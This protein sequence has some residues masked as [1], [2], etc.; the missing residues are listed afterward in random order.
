VA[1]QKL[2][3][4]E[5]KMSKIINEGTVHP[6]YISGAFKNQVEREYVTQP[7]GV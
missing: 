2:L 4:L 6:N 7:V 1:A 5:T 3:L